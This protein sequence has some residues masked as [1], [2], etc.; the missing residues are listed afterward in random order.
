M[1]AFRRL[2]FAIPEQQTLLT[3]DTLMN[4]WASISQFYRALYQE[5]TIMMV[6]V[7]SGPNTTCM[8]TRQAQKGGHL[9]SVGCKEANGG[10]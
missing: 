5:P 9:A 10:R 7:V 8:K 4:G 3:I 6:L 1:T 2:K